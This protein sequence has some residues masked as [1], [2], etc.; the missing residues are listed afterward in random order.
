MKTNQKSSPCHY[1]TGELK[2]VGIIIAQVSLFMGLHEKT[3]SMYSSHALIK[4][5]LLELRRSNF[6]AFFFS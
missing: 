2:S 1:V 5:V 4:K 6:D 3:I